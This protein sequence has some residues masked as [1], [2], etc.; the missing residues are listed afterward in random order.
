MANRY[1]VGNSGNLSDINHWSSTSGGLGGSSVPSFG[2]DVYFDENSFTLDN[3]TV[4]FDISLN[5]SN[6]T[7]MD[8]S[9][10]VIFD[11]FPGTISCASLKIPNSITVIENDGYIF[12]TNNVLSDLVLDVELPK[13][14]FYIF[15]LDSITNLLSD[16][17][18]GVITLIGTFY[19]NGHTIKS[20]YLDLDYCYFTASSSD[21]YVGYYSVPITMPAPT[22]DHIFR[23]SEDNGHFD[24]GTS[25][26]NFYS[27]GAIYNGT[28]NPYIPITF[29]NVNIISSGSVGEY[30]L[31]G[32]SG[33]FGGDVVRH[34]IINNLTIYPNTDVRFTAN[35]VLEVQSKFTCNGIN[36][37]LIY[38]DTEYL[39]YNYYYIK[40]EEVSVSYT[41]V[42]NS[43]AQGTAAPFNDIFGINGGDNNG[44]LFPVPT[45]LAIKTAS[46][47]TTGINGDDVTYT[48]TV[49]N[50]SYAGLGDIIIANLQDDIFGTL[51]GD[52]N[53][54]VGTILTEGEEQS[55]QIVENITSTQTNTFTVTAID[56]LANILT[57]TDT[58]TVTVPPHWTMLKVSGK[59]NCDYLYI[60]N[61]NAT[62]GATFYAG[63]NSTDGGNN[64]GWI[65]E[66]Y[67]HPSHYPSYNKIGLPFVSGV[68]TLGNYSL[69]YPTVLDL[70]YPLSELDEN[71]DFILYGL[72]IG[73]ILV[74]DDAFY[75]SYKFTD[76][77][78]SVYYGVDK[79]DLT[80]KT[81]NS[82]IETRI[83]T[84]DRDVLAMF[85]KVII[86]YSELPTNTD[87]TIKT[88]IDFGAT[89][90]T[91]TKVVDVDRKIIT[92]EIAQ[93]AS[94]F[95]LRLE[96]TT[97]GNTTPAIES[98]NIYLT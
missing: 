97:S 32:S 79:I 77:D 87:V 57:D 11:Q 33:T 14:A 46:P 36:G 43:Y 73:S 65:F 47:T 83:A 67:P 29:N 12:I 80:T 62:G 53:C 24:A 21:I 50:D 22:Y 20:Y 68:Y 85:K 45:V 19:T 37:S 48:Y 23:A 16:L 92:A 64:F 94:V 9:H 7:A 44:W 90:V 69:D 39:T 84:G 81:N 55:F 41:S 61:S 91:H 18:V 58:A 72:E 13:S 59:V 5:A 93:E 27:S 56:E 26:I 63:T 35:Y 38:L 78:D 95:Q 15:N 2:N 1:W 71:G 6:I 17:R 30:L 40:A 8:V 76:I 34:S 70:T 82:Y 3:E 51:V 89:W 88:S 66:A 98:I 49:K 60:K 25:T 54:Q 86:N 42:S 4:I 96:F 52:T 10:P 28:R 75:V 74:M 31:W